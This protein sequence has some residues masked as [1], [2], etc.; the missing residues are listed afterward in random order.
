MTSITIEP[1]PASLD[2]GQT[3]TLVAMVNEEATYKNVTWSSADDSIVSVD[4]EGVV[5]GVEYGTTTITATSESNPEV[6]AT[7]EVTVVYTPVTSISI[8]QTSATL[9]GG[10]T[11]K[12]V[13]TVN[14]DASNKNIIWTSADSNIATVR[15]D[16]TVTGLTTGTVIITGTSE[17][18][19][20]LTVTC[21]VTVTSDYEVPQSGWL[22]PWGRDEAWTMTYN[23]IEYCTEPGNTDW[24]Q[25]GFD[26]SSWGTLTGPMGDVGTYNFYWHTDYNSYQLR[27]KFFVPAVDED[28]TF[29]FYAIID[30]DLWVYVNGELV[31]TFGYGSGEQSLV[32]PAEKFVKGMNQLALIAVEAS[33]D[34]YLDY[35]LYMK[36]P[37]MG[38]KVNLPDCPFEFYYNAADYDETD[39]LIPNHPDANLKGASLVLSENIPELIDNELLRISNRCCGYIDRWENG[40]MESGSHFYRSGEDCMTIVC[41]VAPNYGDGSNASD[42]ICNR[43]WGYNYMWRI[44]EYGSLFLHTGAPHSE[45]PMPINDN[46]PQILAVRVDG[47]HDYIK[48]ENLTTGD[49]LRVN[50][51]NWGSGGNV[52]RFF[53]SNYSSEWFKGDFYWV[54]Y[55][56]ELLTDE[57]LRVFTD[58]FLL[59]DVNA[60]GVVDISDYISEA[61][62]IHGNI[63]DGFVFKAGDIDG[64]GGID[65]TDYIGISN[66]IHTGSPYGGS[67]AGAKTAFP[68]DKSLEHA[69]E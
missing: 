65:I 45:S 14:S 56:F 62:Y 16:G 57:Q 34:S 48:L 54:Y 61:N 40:S 66:I 28:I 19:P 39:K 55:S 1:S 17:A 52:F 4:A 10:E 37:R 7:C 49:T 3:L 15:A 5:T 24:A 29:T 2:K 27:R 26:D 9:E 8:S 18:N 68:F 32:I 13:A 31:G 60:D 42:F 11:V 46:E 64:S 58:D 22:M 25:P 47:V 12:L 23:E 41:K 63:A 30:D 36:A 35:A 53:R 69:P 67:Q 43:E 51:V 21:E 44:G 33:G 6:S 59:G 50:G 38:T 20:E